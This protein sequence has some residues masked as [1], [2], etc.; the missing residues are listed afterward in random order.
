MESG[1]LQVFANTDVS[2]DGR[3]AR[4]HPARP[5]LARRDR[6]RGGRDRLRRLEP[7]AREDG[8]RAH[9]AHARR[10]SD[11][12]RR[13]GA[14]LRD[15]GERDR[16]PDRARHGRVHVRAPGRRRPRDR[17]LR[18]PLDPARPGGDPVDRGGG[19]VADGVPVHAGGLRRSDGARARPDARDR[20]RR[21]GRREVRD[22]RP[23]LAHAR[24]HAD[25]R[26][27]PR[28]EGSLVDRGGVGE[29]RPRRRQVGRR[30]DGERRVAH[31]PPHLR[32]EPL[33]RPPED[34]RAREGANV[35]GVPEDLRHRPP[36]RAVGER[37]RHSALADA[38]PGAGARRSVLRGGR[39]GAAA[40]V[41]GQRAARRE[42]R[43]RAARGRV[44]CPLVVADH[45]RRAPRDARAR[46]HLRP[47]RVRDL[48]RLR[49]RRARRA[50]ARGDG[51]DGRAGRPGRL[52]AGAEPRR[53]LQVRPHDHAARRS[54][55]PRRHRRRP[56]H[57]RPQAVRRCAAGRRVG[58]ARRRD[59]GVDDDRALGAAGARHPRERHLG[60]RLARGLPV[61]PLPDDRDR[62]AAR[63][64]LAHLLRRRPRLGALRAD[65]AG[66]AAVGRALG[67]GRA[68]LA[69]RLR[70][71]RLRDDRT[72]R[73]GLSRLRRRARDGV[74]RRRGRD[75]A[76]Q[77]EGAGLRRQGGAPAPPRGGA[78]RD[79]LHAHD[80][81]S[82][83]G[84]RREALPA[85]ARA[86]RAA[87]RRDAADRR[88]GPPLVRH[89][90]RRR[91]VARQVHPV[92]LPPARA[93]G[94]G[95]GCAGRRVHE[96]ALPGHGRRRRRHARR[97]IPR[98]RG[99]AREDLSSASSACR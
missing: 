64:R 91:A 89:E 29:G 47:L 44:G 85:R 2:G 12:R 32:R 56:R 9:P 79:P 68:A 93:G 28:G 45:Q 11:D 61:R 69:H 87:R 50:A 24:R 58:V 31:R 74:Q 52:H 62:L 27:A 70:D 99:S 26:R 3:R 59:D 43:R 20:R 37:A 6:G 75:G 88:Q 35:R 80:R 21:V 63:A 13:P 1:G 49:G 10:A 15:L 96:R 4:P 67:G 77:R 30:V 83:L 16:V 39:L 82:H 66:R 54:G 18:P 90:R 19:A 53:R 8:R 55:V 36:G 48:R 72:A 97:S 60:R 5:H 65:R 81:R 94:R 98:M 23:H 46:R 86:D 34:A 84:S 17:L 76:A 51:A 57:G 33:P 42:V 95:L 25:P 78:G 41:R 7:A 40:V 92:G 22:Q 73:E 38:R 14:A 71:R